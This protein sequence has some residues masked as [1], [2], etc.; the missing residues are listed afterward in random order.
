MLNISHDAVHHLES[1]FRL[2][3]VE[4][5]RIDPHEVNQELFDK[6]FGP[7]EIKS[8]SE[9]RERVKADLEKMFSRDSDYLFKREFARKYTEMIDPQLPDSFLKKYIALTNEKPVTPEM[10]EHDY[11]YYAAQLRW[12]LIEGKIIRQY[13][14]RVSPDDA[15][16]HVKQILAS[17]YAQY[18]LP[19]EDEMLTEFAKKSLANKEEAKNVYDFLYEEKIVDLVKQNCSLNVTEL[20]YEEFVH[21]VQHQ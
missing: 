16:N 17:R 2:T 6:L 8:E 10:V 3:V 13:E 4:L 20:P 7:D 14:I 9:L 12:E 11:P 1:Q 15:L 19:M 18:G 21:K 5:K